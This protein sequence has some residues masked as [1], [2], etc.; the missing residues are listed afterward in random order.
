MGEFSD[1]IKGN[2]NEA[3]GNLKQDIGDATDNRQMEQ[4]GFEQERKGE[5]Q[6]LRGELKEDAKKTVDRM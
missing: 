2:A 6:Q 1:K 5:A 4:E 3:A